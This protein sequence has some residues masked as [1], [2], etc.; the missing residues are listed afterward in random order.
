M[1]GRGEP[2]NFDN[3]AAASCRIAQA[4]QRNLE[5]V[6]GKLW[7]LKLVIIFTKCSLVPVMLEYII[8]IRR[9]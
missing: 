5:I 9:S 7:A 3:F 8:M 6:R 4:G 1:G 2:Q